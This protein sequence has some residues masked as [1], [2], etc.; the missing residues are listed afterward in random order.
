MTT[1]N[2]M[3]ATDGLLEVLQD[4]V[5]LD[6]QANISLFHPSM[7]QEVQESE[8][9]IKVNGI[10]QMTV[11]RKGNLPGFFDVY[12]H[13][14]VKV[15]V[16]CFV[17]VEDLYEV[18]YR[19]NVGFVVHL[20][21]HEIIFERRNKL[22]VA[23]A[24]EFHAMMM[25]TV[26]EKKLQFSINQVKKAETAYTLLKNAGYPSPGELMSLVSDGNVTNMPVLRRED[27]LWAYEIYGPPPE[28]VRGRLTKSKVGR[29]PVDLALKADDKQQILWGDVM[30]IDKNNFF[31][32][33]ADPLQLILVT[34]L[35]DETAN[36]LG[37]S[38]QGQ[39]EVLRERGFDPVIVHVDP[40]SALMSLRGSFQE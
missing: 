20:D 24:N 4:E 13:E 18:S 30:H 10:Y 7:L 17:D 39:L 12:C 31:I 19:P 36:S 5:L 29:I 40:A 9:I 28:Y 15:N 14:G 37:E 38:L 23:T 25:I 34:H 6:T 32:S 26:E 27:I 22:Y 21:G 33:V 1:F 16:L 35:K 8:K 3:N 2:V 11:L